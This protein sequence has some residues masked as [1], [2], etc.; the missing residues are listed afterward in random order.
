MNYKKIKK[1]LLSLKS[2]NNTTPLEDIKCE[3][4][5]NL[6]NNIATDINNPKPDYE[7]IRQT[8][9]PKYEYY[10]YTVYYEYKLPANSETNSYILNPYNIIKYSISVN[11]ECE[12]SLKQIIAIADYK[13]NTEIGKPPKILDVTESEIKYSYKPIVDDY[14]DIY[15]KYFI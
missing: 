13:Y 3:D 11:S 2:N 8:I 15:K 9:H 12:L 4:K 1:Q 7:A 10:S 5:N 14:N 6:F